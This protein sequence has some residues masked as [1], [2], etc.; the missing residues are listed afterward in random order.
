MY[1]AGGPRPPRGTLTHL[2]FE[3]IDR[4]DRADAMQFK[5]DGKWQ[6]IGHR[7]VEERARRVALGLRA[8]GVKRGDRVALL[9]ENRPEWAMADYGCLTGGQ[10]DV[11][12]YPTLPAEQLPHLLTN[13]GATAVMVSTAAQAAKVAQIRDQAPSV[14]H[15]ISFEAPAP[16][17]ADLTFDELIARGRA[18]ESPEINAAWRRNALAAEPGDL[19]TIIYTSGTTG[20]PKGVML[21]HDNIHSNVVACRTKLPFSGADVELSFLPLS[22]IFQRMF[23]YLAWATGTTIAYA[24][25]IDA[26]AANMGEV[27]PTI[28]CAVPRLYEKMYARVLE[29]VLRGSAVKKR[30][31]FWGRG[32]AARWTDET[33]AGRTPGGW[34]SW[35]YGLARKL[36]FA[37]LHERVGGRLRYFVSGSA[38]LAPEI[39]TFFYGAGLPILEG[40]GLTETSPVISVNAPNAIRIGTVGKPID[41]VE[42]QIAGD[43]EILTRGPHVLKGYYNNPAATQEAITADGWFHTGDIGTLE[44]G[45]LRITDRKKELLKTSGGKYV[46]PQPIEN[47]VKMNEFVAD[48]VLVGDGRKFVALLIVPDFDRLEKW[49]ASRNVSWTDRA[50]LL[51]LPAVREKMD[52]EVLGAFQGLASFETPKKYSL[53][54]REFS[55]ERGELTPS[56]KV[57]RRVIDRNYKTIVDAMYEADTEPQ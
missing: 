33:L 16:A 32:V 52:A 18:D 55:I 8:L 42:V 35:Q 36:V 22:H 38:P 57:K 17:G 3:A 5:A 40:Y 27:R 46:A 24:E 34:L 56:L 28:M 9:S 4:F 7:A 11:P 30:I 6:S 37:K 39:N 43:G 15:V 2:F 13:S 41:G 20:A 25:N 49:A 53:L 44:D 51:A 1:A 48:A 47:R 14:R 29:N 23:D 54:D 19:A 50:A 21:T 31:F 26:V 12:V 45:F 10:I